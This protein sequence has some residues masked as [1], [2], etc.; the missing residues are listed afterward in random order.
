MESN[1]NN[2]LPTPILEEEIEKDNDAFDEGIEENAREEENNANKDRDEPDKLNDPN[3]EK[4]NNNE[5]TR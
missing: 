1:F 3:I 2:N 4:N 5:E